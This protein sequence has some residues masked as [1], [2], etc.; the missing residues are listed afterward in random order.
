MLSVRPGR[1]SF[2]LGTGKES[3][4]RVEDSFRSDTGQLLEKGHSLHV[5]NPSQLGFPGARRLR[6]Q[7]YE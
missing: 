4:V 1:I 5:R 2:P 6:M 7:G 3:E